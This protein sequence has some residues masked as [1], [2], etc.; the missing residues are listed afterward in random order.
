MNNITIDNVVYDHD[1]AHPAED[2][3]D[4]HGTGIIEC[5]NGDCPCQPKEA[6]A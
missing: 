5:W 2:H 6:Q 4:D 3:G 1:C